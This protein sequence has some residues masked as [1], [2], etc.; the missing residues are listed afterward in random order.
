MPL[1]FGDA[2][3]ADGALEIYLP[4]APVAAAIAHRHADPLPA[5]RR[6]P[7]CCSASRSSGSSPAPRGG[8]ATRR[9][10]TRSP[11]CRTAR[12]STTRLSARSAAAARGDRLAALLLIDLDRFKE[13]ND[14]LGHHHGDELLRRG[15]R[16]AAR[17]AAPRRHARPARRRRV[18]RAAPRRCPTAARS[19]SWPAACSDALGRPF[20]LERRRGRAR[21]PASASRCCPDHGDD[22]D[23]LLQR[24]DVA[25]YEAKRARRGHRDLRRRARPL[26]AGPARACSASCAR[27]IER[28]ELVLHYQPKVAVD[29]G[30]RHRRRGARALAA[31]DARPAAAG[32]VRA[33]RRAHRPD[34]RRSRAGCSTTALAPGARVARRRRSTCPSRST[35][36][37][38]NIV[39]ADAARRVARAARARTACRATGSSARSPRTR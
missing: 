36:P 32:G 27:A 30:R 37:A 13:V 24:A 25:M 34:R 26:L 10:T 29:V 2:A 5:A 21:A 38:P 20:A 3:A 4:Y 8:C 7:R 11:A 17:R 16:P 23:T 12:C 19:P 35:S 15:R 39:D 31:P 14:T 33:A 1:R 22:V 28:D 6:R 9:C 18:R